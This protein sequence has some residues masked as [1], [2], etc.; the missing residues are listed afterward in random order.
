MIKREGERQRQREGERGDRQREREEI[1]RER[2][3]DRQTDR[4]TRILTFGGRYINAA[5]MKIVMMTLPVQWAG[6]ISP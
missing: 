4:K 2:E 6:L 5:I 1:D 3:R